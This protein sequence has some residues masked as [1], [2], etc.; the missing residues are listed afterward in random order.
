MKHLAVIFTTGH[1]DTI[2]NACR[3]DMIRYLT[4]HFKITIYTN[5]KE[6]ITKLFPETDVQ[7]IDKGRSA[8]KGYVFQLASFRILARR[9]NQSGADALFMFH[10]TSAVALWMHIPVFQYVHQYGQRSVQNGSSFRG[11]LRNATAFFKERRTFSGL[12]R[13]SV[14]FSVSESIREL[15][16]SR[17]IHNVHTIPHALEL[18]K[19]EKPVETEFHEPL[20]SLRKRGFFIAAY[21]GWMME[22]RGFHLM[23]DALRMAVKKDD[24]VA[25]VMAG[26][27]AHHSEQ[28]QLFKD[29]HELHEHILDLGVVDSSLIPG[30]LASS[31]VCL[32]FLDDVPAFH[33]SPP[34]KVI[35]YFAAGRPVICNYI[36]THNALVRDGYNGL[37][38][39]YDAERLS[40]AILKIKGSPHLQKEMSAN[41]ANTAEMFDANVQYGNMVQIMK[42]KLDGREKIY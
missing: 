24:R 41:A 21:T 3:L 27:D 16:N 8:D 7:S 38:V 6:F 4:G 40:D 42:S 31:D 14:N 15:L 1:A 20:K 9:I 34:Q 5:R 17:G 22:N 28:I 32:S 10:D 39:D 36:Q 19:F 23:L 13:S 2:G 18:G 11:Q 29:S 35:E 26:A 30:I 12:A 37:I 33:L 25:L